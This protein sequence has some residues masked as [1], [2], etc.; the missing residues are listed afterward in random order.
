MLFNF[1]C[2]E[3]IH[4]KCT[5]Y[6]HGMQFDGLRVW[7]DVRSHLNQV[8]HQ[9]KL[10]PIDIQIGFLIHHKY[11][12]NVTYSKSIVRYIIDPSLDKNALGFSN[13][14]AIQRFS[15]LIFVHLVF[16]TFVRNYWIIIFLGNWYNESPIIEFTRFTS[17]QELWE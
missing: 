17:L 2:I 6:T 9:W 13:R 5:C 4:L 16:L 8:K 15:Y 3:K 12:C 10:R 11:K 14:E 1:Y 7:Q